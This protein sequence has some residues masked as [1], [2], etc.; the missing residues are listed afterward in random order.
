MPLS[1]A[2]KILYL[3]VEEN[4]LD[5]DIVDLFMHSGLVYDY[6]RKYLSE[7]QIDIELPPQETEAEKWEFNI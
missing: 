4:H 6:A 5:Q 7:D 1:Q 2:I 3:M